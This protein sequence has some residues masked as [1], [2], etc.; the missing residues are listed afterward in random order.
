MEVTF[1]NNKLER[2]YRESEFGRRTFGAAIARAY[3]RAINEL[4]D[5][6]TIEQMKVLRPR[7]F[8]LLKPK[9]NRRFAIDLT[10][11]FRLI[12]EATDKPHQFRVLS[13]EDY[14]DH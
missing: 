13:V 6:E 11:N 3:I 2:C 9:R 5:I 8:H 12:V 10:G 7:R 1:R 14:H 4:C